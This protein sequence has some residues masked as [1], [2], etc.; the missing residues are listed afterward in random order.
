MLVIRFVFAGQL[1]FRISFLNM[2]IP[3]G[4]CC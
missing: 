2:V 3:N 1:M 4:E